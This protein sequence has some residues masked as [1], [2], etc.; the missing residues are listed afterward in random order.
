M[1]HKN[2]EVFAL[3]VNKAPIRQEDVLYFSADG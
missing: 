1:A 2:R 3:L